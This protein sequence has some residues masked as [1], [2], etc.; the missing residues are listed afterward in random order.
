M[1]PEAQARES[2]DARL[3]AT[4]WIIQDYKAAGSA[5]PQ[6]PKKCIA[7]EVERRLSV[8]AELETVVTANLTRAT[9]L[10]QATLHIAFAGRSRSESS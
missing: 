10:R 5:P 4:G 2:I 3:A 7:A 9:R 1:K 6:S 8:V